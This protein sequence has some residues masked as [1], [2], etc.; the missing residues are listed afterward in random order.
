MSVL[1]IYS[2]KRRWLA[3]N[4]LACEQALCLGK[5]SEEREGKGGA[6]PSP[7]LARP[8]AC[9]QASNLLL[10]PLVGKSKVPFHTGWYC[11][12][13]RIFNPACWPKTIAHDCWL[14]FLFPE[15]L[16]SEL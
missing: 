9:S 10:L 16:A 3:R 6:F 7:H 12:F 4:L 1:A 11:V 13:F 14:G 15:S 8:K 5:N 2:M